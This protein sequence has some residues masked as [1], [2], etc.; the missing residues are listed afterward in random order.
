MNLNCIFNAIYITNF[1]LMKTGYRTYLKK[2]HLKVFDEYIK[3]L[4]S[5]TN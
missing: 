1:L 2:R 4:E 3:S 5:S